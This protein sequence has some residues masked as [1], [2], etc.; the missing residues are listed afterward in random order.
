MTSTLLPD[1]EIQT[2]QSYD[3]YDHPERYAHI[4]KRS[5]ALD[6]YVNGKPIEALCG[7]V[8]VPS[9]NPEDKPICQGCKNVYEDDEAR[10]HVAGW[11][12]KND[13]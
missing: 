11:R 2:T 5:E 10:S 9:E 4:I 6:G 3:F 12:G 1:T 7:H 13:Y 8:F